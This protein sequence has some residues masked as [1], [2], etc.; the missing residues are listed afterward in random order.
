MDK[1]KK[2]DDSIAGLLEW[3]NVSE[4]DARKQQSEAIAADPRVL[5]KQLEETKARNRVTAVCVENLRNADENKISLFF[6]T[7]CR[8]VRLLIY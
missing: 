4:E 8:E 7:L 2:Y 3:L 6:S 1:Y 5:Q